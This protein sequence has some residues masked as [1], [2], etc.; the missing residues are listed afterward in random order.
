[1]SAIWDAQD[2]L[3]DLRAGRFRRDSVRLD[4]RHRMDP[5][6]FTDDELERDLKGRIIVVVPLET[7]RAG[8]RRYNLRNSLLL[9]SIKTAA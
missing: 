2:E 8:A 3:A 6:M 7:F 5:D 1:M 9:R 4:Q